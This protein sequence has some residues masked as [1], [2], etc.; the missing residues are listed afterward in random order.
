MWA[1]LDKDNTTV[2]GCITPDKTEE[3]AV[4]M[5]NGNTIIRMTLENSPG[6]INGIY[7]N[8]KFYPPENYTLKEL[9]N[10]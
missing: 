10:G 2:I 5:S 3:E 9:N 4:K 8:G 7:K 6:W 1:I